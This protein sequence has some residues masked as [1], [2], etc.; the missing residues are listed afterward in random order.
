[1]LHTAAR[2]YPLSYNVSQDAVGD[3]WLYVSVEVAADRARAI[4]AERRVD[5]NLGLKDAAVTSDPRCL[6]SALLRN[7]WAARN[8]RFS[9]LIAGQ[10]HSDRRYSAA[11]RRL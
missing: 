10:T 11:R 5:I 6:R 1:V 2:A 3:W 8:V 7:S 9:Q 4:A